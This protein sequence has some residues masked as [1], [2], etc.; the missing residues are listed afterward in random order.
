MVI[1]FAFGRLKGCFGC[2]RKVMYFLEVIYGCFILHN[3]CEIDNDAILLTR[4]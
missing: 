1:E 3:Y 2:L 4:G